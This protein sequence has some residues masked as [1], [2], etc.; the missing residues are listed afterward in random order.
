[1]FLEWVLDY[2]QVFV[3]C[4]DSLIVAVI[5]KPPAGVETF[6]DDDDDDLVYYRC[7]IL[8]LTRQEWFLVSVLLK[9]ILVILALQKF[10]LPPSAS[11]WKRKLYYFLRNK[12][13]LPG[14]NSLIF[15]KHHL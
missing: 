10:K 14:E 6:D 15:H 12:L 1:M 4:V 9:S 5:P 13:K 8:C 11:R 3:S 7:L 2:A